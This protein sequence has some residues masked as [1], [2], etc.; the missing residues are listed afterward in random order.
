MNDLSEADRAVLQAIQ[1]L[2]IQ[3]NGQPPTLAEIAVYLGLQTSSRGNIQR[4]LR[5]LRP[6]YVDWTDSPRSLRITPTGLARI[7]AV[8]LTNPAS[9]FPI[10]EMVLP[11]L[12][13]G[14]TTISQ[15]VASGKLLQV[16]YPVA[17]QRGMNILAVECLIRGIVPPSHTLEALAWCRQPVA[18]WPLHFAETTRL[19]DQPL[20]EDDQ[21]SELCRE[22]ARGLPAGEAELELS[23]RWILTVQ[24]TAARQGLAG[25]YVA[26][27][28]YLVEHPVV[29]PEELLA[30]SLNPQ[31]APFVAEIQEMYEEVPSTVVEQGQIYLCG[32][33]GWTLERRHDRLQCGDPR[34]RTLTANFTR[35][36]QTRAWNPQLPL[37][38]V[39]RA[40]RRYV[41]APG[42]YEVSTARRLAALGVEVAL[43]PNYDQYDLRIT[44]DE[45]EVWGV[46]VKDWRYPHLLARHIETALAET[47]E[48][49]SGPLGR[50]IYAVPD[51]RAQETRT[52]L[53]LL[54]GVLRR[55]GVE[56]W[57]LS[58]LIEAVRER[59]QVPHA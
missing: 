13:S 41:V 46:D 23:E 35:D 51:E 47:E 40:I 8:P 14:L 58:E 30:A 25:G 34:C 52:Y 26:V 37:L 5:R 16:P 6:Q 24:Q 54:R 44:F 55:P 18:S 27:R 22:L 12:A 28:R 38:R 36:T 32:F 45:G 49:A 31:M 10:P 20:L 4:Q 21:P 1:E 19:Y 2:T 48:G 11:L 39:R 15:A 17:W 9:D 7:K 59:K 42:I 56:I 43:W 29:E 50:I 53:P 3:H 33:C 57:T